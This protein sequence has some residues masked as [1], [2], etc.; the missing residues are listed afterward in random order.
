MWPR[1]R[2]GDD[3]PRP[4]LGWRL[5]GLAVAVGLFALV[6]TF[7]I[8]IAKA[9]VLLLMPFIGLFII[10]RFLLGKLPWKK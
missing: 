5:V 4:P 1:F 6:M 3:A 9:V 8:E 2:H 10:Y 7:A